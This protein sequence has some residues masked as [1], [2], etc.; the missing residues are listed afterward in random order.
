[1][2][3]AT[4]AAP[5]E[6]IQCTSCQ[7]CTLME[8][9][10]IMRTSVAAI[11]SFQSDAWWGSAVSNEPGADSL[12]W[13]S[14]IPWQVCSDSTQSSQLKRNY[15]V[16]LLPLPCLQ[17]QM[18]PNYTRWLNSLFVIVSISLSN[19]KW[20]MPLLHLWASSSDAC[21]PNCVSSCHWIVLTTF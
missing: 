10:W 18:W 15:F 13:L 1:M 16:Y 19:L 9:L 11:S 14:N 21:S 4:Q 12:C 7:E 2:L 8:A 6:H 5:R 3:S 20:L 17:G